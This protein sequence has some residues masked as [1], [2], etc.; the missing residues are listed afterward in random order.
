MKSVFNEMLDSL[1][2]LC[3]QQ[4][5]GGSTISNFRVLRHRDVYKCFCRWMDNIK[6][7]HDSGAIITD[8]GLLAIKDKFVHT[9]RP[10]SRT[11][12]LGYSLARI[13]VRDDLCFALRSVSTLLQ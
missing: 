1:E 3:G 9:A 7:A 6:Q 13:D 5:N 8:G 11:H 12:S 2:H 10:E 4:D